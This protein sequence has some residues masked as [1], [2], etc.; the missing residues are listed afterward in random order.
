MSRERPNIGLIRRRLPI[1]ILL[2]AFSFPLFAS[3]KEKNQ[4]EQILEEAKAKTDIRDTSPFEM[5]A[6][7]TIDQKGQPID[8]SYLFIWNGPTQ[9]REEIVFPGYTEIQVGGKE[10]VYV[11][12]SMDFMPYKIYQLHEV[13]AYGS[14]FG[15]GPVEKIKRTHDRDLNGKKALCVEL[16]AGSS[17]SS[18]DVCVDASTGAVIREAPF[19]DSDFEPFGQ[20]LFPRLMSYVEHGKTLIEVKITGLDKTEPLPPSAFSAPSGAIS[21][22]T[23]ASPGKGRLVKRVDPQY[24]PA[25]RFARAQGTVTLYGVIGADGAL[26]GLQVVSGVTSGL[27]QA[28]LDAVQ[29]WRYEPY[30]CNGVPI[31]VES[32]VSVNFTLGR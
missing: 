5:K 24:P 10:V 27:N 28:S 22:P 20:K 30:T 29:Q 21:K 31:D 6:N 2:C 23:C 19:M 1:L 15:V 7:L 9:W 26:H 8:G 4:G 18:R 25:E 14:H 12:R 3:G 32:V 17:F 16:V 13:L 11:K